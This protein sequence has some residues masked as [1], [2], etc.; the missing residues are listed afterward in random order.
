MVTFDGIVAADGSGMS[1]QEGMAST[2]FLLGKLSVP[3]RGFCGM[4]NMGNVFSMQLEQQPSPFPKGEKHVFPTFSNY[5]LDPTAH[6]PA[7]SH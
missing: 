2:W 5:Q 7:L 4:K 1:P 6:L 3:D